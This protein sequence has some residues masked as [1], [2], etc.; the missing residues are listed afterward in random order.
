MNKGAFV[1]LLFLS[2]HLFLHVHIRHVNKRR[3]R[4]S[5]EMEPLGSGLSLEKGQVSGL[6]V[7]LLPD[8]LNSEYKAQVCVCVLMH[9]L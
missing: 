7:F 9:F 1:F 5:A 4:T 3:R 6:S 2:P 8:M